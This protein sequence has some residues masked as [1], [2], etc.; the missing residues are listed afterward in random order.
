MIQFRY[1]DCMMKITAAPNSELPIIPGESSEYVTYNP[2]T[3]TFYVDIS[4]IEHSFKDNT[5][6]T[7]NPCHG[8]FIKG[9]ERTLFFKHVNID[10]EEEGA[11]A[12][13]QYRNNEV[14]CNLVIFND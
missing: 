8:V 5:G 7:F 9:R 11:A 1:N 10:R 4:D 14:D 13:W 12:A 2:K 3:R 6:L